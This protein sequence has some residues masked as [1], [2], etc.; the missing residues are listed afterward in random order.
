M[1][2]STFTKLM[3][4]FVA[5]IV[6]CV[7]LLFSVFYFT[8]RDLQ[9]QTR[10]DALRLQ[11]YDIA[12]L[13]GTLQVRALE[14]LLGGV[15]PIREVLE[16]KLQYVYDEYSAYCMV[17][18]RR[19][20]V[21]AYFL[22]ILNDHRDLKAAFDA[23]NIIS[24]LKTVLEGNEVIVQNDTTYGPMFTVA[25]PWSQ[26][27]HVLGAVYIQTAAQTV[28]ASY[29]SLGL[30]VLAASL[31]ATLVAAGIVF[32]YTRRFI[33]PLTE[34][35]SAAAA[36]SSGHFEKEVSEEGTRELHDLAVAFNLMA[37]KLKVAERARRDFIA[38]L[39]HELR[40]PMTS[41][42]GFIQGLMDG[43]VPEIEKTHY[44]EVIL[45]ETQR[46]TKLVSRLLSL[47]RLENDDLPLSP[48]NF[49]LN[50]L[51]RIVLITKVTQLEEKLI[52][53][54]LLFDEE[55]CYVH[56]D[57][58][59]IEQVLINLIDNAIRFTPEHGE[60]TVSTRRTAAD[61]VTASVKDNGIGVHPA[62]APFVFDRF[63][64]AD[65]AHSEGQGTGLGLAICKMI[66][67]RHRQSIRLIPMDNGAVFEFTLS[68]GKDAL[69]RNET[70]GARED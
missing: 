13:A 16:K 35:A 36:M 62:D 53:I 47:A 45:T 60:I 3:L 66:L 68:K 55:T 12:Y 58:D 9:I 63:F 43:T 23:S 8:M 64:K 15:Q 39:S 22:S 46:M 38:N 40:S 18:D 1:R 52:D 37:R 44:L 61:T 7:S 34:M 41:I 11:A 56:A 17:V 65:K 5:V 51:I 70:Q 67:D 6:L 59:Q 57:R 25:V 4:V 28:K 14:H 31:V 48:S 19:G 49:D 26:G 54:R 29:K 21:T 20:D 33:Q 10:M 69:L 30:K 50:E 42:Q 32:L 2:P 27:G 24:T